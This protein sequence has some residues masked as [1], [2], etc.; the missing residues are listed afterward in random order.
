[1]FDEYVEHAAPGVHG[2]IAGLAFP[3]VQYE[4]FE[5]SPF[6]NEDETA[7]YGE[8]SD[9]PPL[10]PA[11][12]KAP[13]FEL[14]RVQYTL[15]APLVS[16][17]VSSDV[18]AM[19]LS[20]NV[21]VLIVLAHSEQVV[22][23]PIPRKQTE[24]TLYKLF[25]D[26][27]GRHLLVS[28][29]QGETWYLYRGWKKPKQLKQLKMIIESVA[30]NRSAL[31]SS[32]HSTSTRE[33]LIGARNGSVYEAIIDAEED[34]FKPPDRHCQ[35]VFT[36]PERPP[37]TGIRYDYFPPSD[38][39][40]VLVIVTSPS[41]IYQFVG[42][43]DR[44]A[45]ESGRAFSTLF[46]NY[47]DT[48]PNIR[49]LPNNLQTSELHFYTPNADQAQSLPKMLAWQ[50]GPGMY[51]GTLN[52]E[53][54]SDDF[55]DNAGL[56]PYPAFDQPEEVPISSSL[57]EFHF[58]L[59]YKD[60]VVAVNSLDERLAY[61]ETIPLK[62]TEE[63]RG[64][65]ADPVRQT[66]WIYTDQSLFELVASNEDR[67][68]WSTYLA[69]GIYD[70]ALQY[71]KTAKQRDIVLSRQAQQ[72]FD[73][74]RYFQAAQAYAASSVSFEEVTLKFL[75]LGERDAL[76]SYLVSR[77][78]RTKKTDLT[79][80]MM[81][82]TWLVEF[83][84]SKCNELDDL[85]ASEAL[86][87]DVDNLQAERRI[88]EDD[89]RHFFETY[90]TSLDKSTV[91]ELTQGHGRTDMY[92]HYAGVVGDLDRVIEHWVLEEEWTKAIDVLSRQTNLEL[93]YRFANVLMRNAPRET[94][95]SWLRQSSLD[96][97]RLVPALLQQ[98]PLPRDPTSPNHA[99]R[100]LNHV[101]FQKG[102]TSAT[103][104]NLLITFHASAPLPSS[105]T[106]PPASEDDAPLLRFLSTAPSD[107]LTNKPFYDLDYA[108]RLCKQTGRT[109]ACV[110]IYSKMGLYENSVDL[111]LEKGD[112]ELAKINADMPEDDVQ[113]RKKLWLKIAKYVV[114]D[115]KDIK[116]AMRFLQNTDLLKIE[117]I[118]PFFPD[119]AVIDDFKDEICTALE[120]YASQID[121]LKGEMDEA[122]RNADAIKGD[123]AALRN[124]FVTIDAGERCAVCRFPVLTR[125]FYV[126]PCQHCF[127]ADCLIGLAKEYLPAHALRRILALQGELVKT[128][129][130][131]RGNIT[132]PTA[133]V[134]NAH[135][136]QPSTQRT[137]LSA[138]FGNLA[139]PL[140]NGT[141]A[142]N[143]LGRNILSAGDRLR[144]LIVPDALV[145]V[146]SNPW[147]GITGSG[148]RSG[149]DSSKEEK[150]S[151]LRAE[152]D[153]VLASACPLCESVVAGLD[154]PFVKE[155]EIDTS[156]AL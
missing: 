93:Y 99:I 110:H 57:T 154:K 12:A 105:S 34:F 87:H 27:S 94:V 91:Y 8:T 155:G 120:D 129:Q 80:R 121:A 61:D 55:I 22:K 21:I 148:R 73:D 84:L 122:T 118:L 17:A 125:Q 90:Q 140:Q 132:G 52:F 47:R 71:T 74:G 112:L 128:A 49:D 111:A 135:V 30:W 134:Q 100:Y 19:G 2:H 88:L 138:N 156:W 23:I 14:G 65:A 149:K 106:S 38:P 69:K 11:A 137:L 16:L 54:A 67:D 36:L 124:R 83:Y 10:D 1:M 25:L 126:F 72:F 45:Q 116:S 117:D 152:L 130:V 89:L 115:Q 113:L 101:V 86:S 143:S 119:F 123:I 42:S 95:E 136:R 3:E 142:A 32:P 145:S 98:Q 127:H 46:A 24:F 104:H 131:D 150:A 139:N 20:S 141:R 66:Y 78:E 114:Q 147:I 82:A 4:G 35:T 7:E 58:L 63:V 39:R 28:S 96:P 5:P 64:M 13:V 59:L 9:G 50:S 43:P 44:A 51:H 15:P 85:I 76:R 26:P 97:L 6:A 151:K 62:P 109:Q 60:R 108:L 107:P 53:S 153:D 70:V 29:L 133:A 31:L 144:D 81:L 18:L 68:I 48:A 75:D 77:L 37:V 92:L 102:N 41:R 103:I 33:V 40:K 56:F 79:Q 146:V